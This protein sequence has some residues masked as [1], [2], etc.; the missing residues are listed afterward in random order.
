MIRAA[1][2]DKDRDITY[3]SISIPELFLQQPLF[4]LYYFFIY[5]SAPSSCGKRRT[6]RRCTAVPTVPALSHEKHGTKALLRI[7]KS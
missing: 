6:L 7:H 3:L 4:L 1:A 5:L 2:N